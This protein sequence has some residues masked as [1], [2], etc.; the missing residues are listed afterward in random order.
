MVDYHIV[1]DWAKTQAYGPFPSLSAAEDWLA[2]Q[3]ILIGQY[4]DNDVSIV[5]LFSVN[6]KLPVLVK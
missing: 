4:E 1:F 5:P 3:Q 2:A 6:E